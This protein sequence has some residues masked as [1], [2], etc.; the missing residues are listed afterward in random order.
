[1]SRSNL[2]LLTISSMILLFGCNQGGFLDSD[3]TEADALLNVNPEAVEVDA[4]SFYVDS[5]ITEVVTLTSSRSWS[6]A[7]SEESPW[8]S[9]SHKNGTNLG[10]VLKEWPVTLKFEDNYGEDRQTSVCVTVEGNRVE[11]PVLQKKFQPVLELVSPSSCTLPEEGG[12]VEIAVRSNCRW[13]ASISG[14]ANASISKVEGTKSDNLLCTLKSNLDTSSE[15]ESTVIISAEG[16]PDVMVNINQAICIPR[17]EVDLEQ[18]ETDV[19]PVEG[20]V[21]LIFSTN[22]SWTAVLEDG[23]A[24]GVL[25]SANAGKLSDRLYIHFPN[26]TIEDA[27]ATVVITTASG[28]S[29]KVTFTQRGCIFI[30]FRIYPDNNGATKSYQ[31]WKLSD[32][33]SKVPTR[34]T[35]DMGAGTWNVVDSN[36]NSYVICSGTTES[37]FYGEACGLTL[38]SVVENPAFYIQFPA[39]EGK[40][41]KGVKVMLGNSDVPLKDGSNCEPLAKGTNGWI[42]DTQNNVVSGG[43]PRDV[44]TYQKDNDWNTTQ[45][46]PSF[47]SDYHNHLE[48]MFHFELSETTPGAAYRFAGNDRMVIRWFILYYE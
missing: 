10:K 28:L 40:T 46:I 20:D 41:L 22:E 34:K 21:E 27:V 9:I 30:P 12:I 45:T 35:A 7:A 43:E 14:T 3:F 4:A 17:L 23:A 18:T 39:L 8:L 42:T 15:K 5:T 37:V 19:L 16:A 26:A 13:T 31:P 29:E 32:G 11:L 38:G 44:R 48:S 25:L 2:I 1:M 6:L 36:N 24:N 47:H 33:G